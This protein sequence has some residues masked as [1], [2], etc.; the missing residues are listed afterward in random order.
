MRLKTIF[1]LFIL[2]PPL[3]FPKLFAQQEQIPAPGKIVVKVDAVLVPVVVRDSHGRPVGNLKKEDFRVF[4]QNKERPI[5]G[6]SMEARNAPETSSTTA[7]PVSSGAAPAAPQTATAPPHRF[8]V[9][10][11]DDMHLSDGDLLRMQGVAKKMISSSLKETDLAA[12]VSVSG[13]NSGLTRDRAKLEDTIAKIKV[14]NIYRP[15]GGEC[16]N[17][18]YYEAD[19]IQNRHDDSALQEAEQNFMTCANVTGMTAMAV[20]RMVEGAA[21]RAL[22][23]G[24]QDVHVSLAFIREVVRKMVSLPGQ[25]TLVLLSP[26]FL[27]ITPEALSQKSQTIDLAAQSDVTISALDAR[28]LYT[29]EQ[30]AS[31]RGASSSMALQTGQESQNHRESMTSSEN[32]MAELA[33]GT[34]GSYFHNNNDLEAGLGQLIAG[35]EYLYLLECPLEGVK[36]DGTYHRLQ[37]KVNQEGLKIQARHGYFAPKPPKEHK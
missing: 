10:L 25:R 16:P 2:L 36:Q 4:D 23:L 31:Q 26:G 22:L 5:S 19:R 12:V 11:F 33:D 28:G 14:Q 27:T 1:L 34:G 17:I 18:T 8:V 32:V 21:S 35:P 3:N 13:T 6:F 9:L 24:D 7:N 20:E 37:V 29:L 15:S 30:D